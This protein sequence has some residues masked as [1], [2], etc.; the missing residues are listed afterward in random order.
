MVLQAQDTHHQYAEYG[1]LLYTRL[2]SAP[3]PHP[4]RASGHTYGNLQFPADKHYSDSSVAIFIRSDLGHDM[5]LHGR[6]QYRDYLKA[7][8]LPDR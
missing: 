6:M 5:V 3:F 7:S 8:G 4:R 1:E 2:S